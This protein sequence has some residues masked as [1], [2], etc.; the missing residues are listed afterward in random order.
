MVGDAIDDAV[1]SRRWRGIDGRQRQCVGLFVQRSRRENADDE[2]N[3]HRQVDDEK[4]QMMGQRET[5]LI[6]ARRNGPANEDNSR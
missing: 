5:E 3:D 4:H 1:G 2:A 6:H